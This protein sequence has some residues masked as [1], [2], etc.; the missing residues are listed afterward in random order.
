[1]ATPSYPSYPVNHRIP[2]ETMLTWPGTPDHARLNAA[3]RLYK[4]VQ[5]HQITPEGLSTIKS[6]TPSDHDDYL[7]Y[8]ERLAAHQF[9]HTARQAYTLRRRANTDSNIV[10]PIMDIARTGTDE[11]TIGIAVVSTPP[12]TEHN[13][14]THLTAFTRLPRNTHWTG[15]DPI[16]TQLKDLD[17]LVLQDPKTQDPTVDIVLAFPPRLSPDIDATDTFPRGEPLALREILIHHAPK[18]VRWMVI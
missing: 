10:D 5:D 3:A 12:P 18:S 15:L 6:H 11:R 14:G 1:M 16:L 8:Q 17:V 9:R 4:Q 7:C 2:L 13:K